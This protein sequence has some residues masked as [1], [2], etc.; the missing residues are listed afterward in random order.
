M[1]KVWLEPIKTKRTFKGKKM[2]IWL[3]IIFI[4][5]AAVVVIV[6]FAPPAVEM[7]PR[8]VD[9]SIAE[10]SPDIA[11]KFKQLCREARSKK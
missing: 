7:F 4:S 8:R 5:T 10:I 3:A 11:P 2:N 1:E 6:L 9:C